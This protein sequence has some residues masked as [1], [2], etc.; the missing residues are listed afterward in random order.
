MH[1][2][3]TTRDPR[4]REKSLPVCFTGIDKQSDEEDWDRMPKKAEVI[5]RLLGAT[6]DQADGGCQKV[7]PTIEGEIAIL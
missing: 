1:S 3:L 4:M 2:A 5:E 6:C 7:D